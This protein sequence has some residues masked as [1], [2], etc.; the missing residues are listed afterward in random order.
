MENVFFLDEDYDYSDYGTMSFYVRNNSA[1][2]ITLRGVRFY[3]NSV[4]WYSPAVDG[5]RTPQAAIPADGEWHKI[6]LNL[7]RVYLNGNEGGIGYTNERL[8][9]VR[10]I[11]FVFNSKSDEGAEL[12]LDNI[13][14]TPSAEEVKTDFTPEIKNIDNVLELISAIFVNIIG[15]IVGF[16]R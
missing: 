14:F 6:T 8:D 10:E 7:N 1:D 15:L 11:E 2:D 9:T 12:T 16:F 13:T 5:T 3:V 4:S